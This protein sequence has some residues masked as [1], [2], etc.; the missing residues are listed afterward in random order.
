VQGCIFYNSL[1]KN[2][3]LALICALFVLAGLASGLAT[4]TPWGIAFFGLGTLLF[5]YRTFDRRP[6]VVVNDRG[7]NDLRNSVGI[8]Q[9]SE[10]TDARFSP[11]SRTAFIFVTVRE[12][13]QWRTRLPLAYRVFWMYFQKRRIINIALLNMTLAGNSVQDCLALWS[14]Q[15]DR[16]RTAN[17]EVS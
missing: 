5:G 6:R 4:K 2:S 1:W 16:T 7:I 8:I 10:M 11:G 15:G 3:I 9:W 14:P 17:S 13:N 12:P